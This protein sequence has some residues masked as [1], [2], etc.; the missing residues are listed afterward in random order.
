VVASLVACA[1][2]T[3]SSPAKANLN[4]DVIT[5]GS[6]DFDESV[7]LAEVYSQG[8]E[9]AGYTVNRQFSLGPREFVGPAL[10]AG[11]V[12]LVP[13]YAATAAEFYSLGEAEPTDD[14]AVTHTALV[15]AIDGTPLDALAAA[16][17]QDTNTFVVTG[18]TAERLHLQTV[19]DL[20]PFAGE[21]TFGGPPECRTRSLCFAGLQDTYG[22]QFAQFVALDAS[23]PLTHDALANGLVDVAVMF[24]TDP[25]IADQGLVELEDDRALQSAENVTP[26]IRTE[27]VDRFGPDVVAVIDNVSAELT[28]DAVRHL[29]AAVRLSGSDP[30]TVAAAW[31]NDLEP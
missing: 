8:L 14:V 10:S 18:E 26:L 12:E 11:L 22:L 23:G 21:L 28:T 27:L 19:S 5:V 7:L 25:T 31:W 1:S 30:A 13:E 24:T 15:N 2:D 17:A 3:D 20:L 6:F 29:N 9:S 16:P 4:D